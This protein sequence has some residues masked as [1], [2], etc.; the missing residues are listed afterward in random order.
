MTS[1]S[2]YTECYAMITF[3]SLRWSKLVQMPIWSK[4]LLF[5]S[6]Q[7]KWSKRIT[8]DLL[9]RYTMG[10][11]LLRMCIKL[12]N[13]MMVHLAI[14]KGCCLS[15]ILYTPPLTTYNDHPLGARRLQTFFLYRYITD[16]L[17]R[18]TIHGTVMKHVGIDIHIIIISLK[19]CTEM[20]T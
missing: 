10:E 13:T 3:D 12:T 18:Y 8:V 16:C 11:V 19:F 17:C 14:T 1:N 15:L 6:T 7:A 4:Y 5:L 20:L 2:P 9:I